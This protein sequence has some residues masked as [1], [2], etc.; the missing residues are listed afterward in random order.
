MKIIKSSNKHKTISFVVLTPDE[1]DRNGDIITKDEI[2]K[3]AHEFGK[4]MTKKFL[5]ID[6]RQWTE[7]DKK[8]YEFVES[9]IAPNDILIWKTFIACGSWYLWIKFKN[10]KLYKDILNG[11]YVGISMEWYFT[12]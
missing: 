7:I 3:T 10:E 12:E 6:H 2:I 5:N 4:N 11:E 1:E 9:F 8:D